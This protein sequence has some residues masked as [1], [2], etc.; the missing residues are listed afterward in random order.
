MA[1]RKQGAQAGKPIGSH[2]AQGDKLGEAVFDLRAQERGAFDKLLEERRPVLA[3]EI[4]NLVALALGAGRIVGE[5]PVPHV[6]RR[7]AEAG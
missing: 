5:G 1:R 3:N 6:E 4:E 7:G 2:Q